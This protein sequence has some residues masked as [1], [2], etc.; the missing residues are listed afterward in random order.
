MANKGNLDTKIDTSAL[1]EV[2]VFASTYRQDVTEASNEIRTICQSMENEESLQGGDGDIIRENFR[3]IAMGCNNLDK[4]TEKI[5]KVLN[6]KLSAAIKMRHG[7]S[8]GDST[9][10]AKS[11]T[12]RVGVL[13][14]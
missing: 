5:V 11:A 3:T 4:S 13:K 12:S 9:D 6:D 10:K 8:V 7:Q 14:E 1:N 2:I